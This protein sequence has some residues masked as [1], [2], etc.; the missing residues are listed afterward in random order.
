MNEKI[1]ALIDAEL[2]EL[3]ERRALDAM[4]HDVALRGTWERY[5]LIRS[6][7]TRQL[8]VLAPHDL[9]ERVRL[10]ID[11]SS[12]APSASLR[13]WPLVGGFAAAASVALVAFLGLQAW[14][15][16]AARVAPVAVAPANV[17][18]AEKS[19]GGAAQPVA[20]NVTSV[21]P[22]KTSARG[23]QDRLHY[24][25][26]GHNEFMPTGTMG[27]MLPYVRVVSDS[28]EK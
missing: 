13:F 1:S 15:V 16:P 22:E 7:M 6:A 12:I 24:Y 28:P 25:L 11:G 20:T 21:A 5:H 8:G 23:A 2:D 19:V 17:M 18:V 4:K 3:D 9:T 14:R 26:F 27:S 10:E